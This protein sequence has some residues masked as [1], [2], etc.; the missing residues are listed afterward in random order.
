MEAL[1]IGV[2][3]EKR[4]VSVLYT[5]QYSNYFIWGP[6]LRSRPCLSTPLYAESLLSSDSSPADALLISSQ[7]YSYIYIDHFKF[8]FL[9]QWHN[10]GI[11][12]TAVNPK[13]VDYILLLFTTREVT[14]F[15]CT[16]YRQ[17]LYQRGHLVSLLEICL[18]VTAHWRIH[19]NTQKVTGCMPISYNTRL[20]GNRA[21][22][23]LTGRPIQISAQVANQTAC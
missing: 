14:S 2:H 17:D 5:I 15:W 7:P 4:Y 20:F 8:L 21:D 12:M 6:S 19:Y 18:I 23:A 22:R 13:T 3:C 11:A 10:D 1:L 16:W 9:T